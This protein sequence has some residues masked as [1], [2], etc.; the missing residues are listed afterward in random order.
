VWV[1]ADSNH[2]KI[3]TSCFRAFVTREITVHEESRRYE[4]LLVMCDRCSHMCDSCRGVSVTEVSLTSARHTFCTNQP[5]YYSATTH[6]WSLSSIELCSQGL[7][8]YNVLQIDF[9]CRGRR[10][11]CCCT[12]GRNSSAGKLSLFAF[13][14]TNQTSRNLV[15][16]TKKRLFLHQQDV[17]TRVDVVNLEVSWF[18]ADK[19]AHFWCIAMS[20]YLHGTLYLRDVIEDTL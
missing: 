3:K 16:K 7:E 18:R 15:Q 11:Y 17:F 10:A 20:G 9:R 6:F 5:V 13:Q 19:I 4:F 8:M 14:A 2:L 12:A 1:F